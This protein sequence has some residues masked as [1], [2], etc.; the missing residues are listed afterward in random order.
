MERKFFYSTKNKTK[1]KKLQVII[2]RRQRDYIEIDPDDKY[3][4]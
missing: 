1:K 2:D 3:L 4:C